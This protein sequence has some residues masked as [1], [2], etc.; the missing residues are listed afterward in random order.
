MMPSSRCCSILPLLVVILVI[1]L[2]GGSCS[3]RKLNSKRHEAPVHGALNHHSNLPFDSNQ[4]PAFYRAYP[5]LAKYRENVSEVYR[6]HR[7]T[8]IWYDTNGVVEFGQTLFGKVGE[9]KDEGISSRFPYTDQINDIFE[10]EKENKLTR[11]ETDIMLTNLY[12]FYTDKV[13]K[14][15]DDTTSTAL[16]WLLPRKELSYPALLDSVIADKQLIDRNDSI[17]YSQYYKLRDVLQ[18]YREIERKGGWKTIEINPKVKSFKPG[19]TAGTIR[20]IRERLFITGDL[21]QD[22]KS[23]RYDE[24]LAAA[25]KK[26]QR[27]NGFN[28]VDRILPEHIRQMNVPIAERIKKIIVNMERCRWIS[29]EFAKSTEYIVVNIPSFRLTF[30]RNGKI[31]LESPVIVGRNVNKTVIFSGMLSYIVFSPYWNVP[32][33]IISKE[34]K[35]GMA[36]DKNYLEKHD[37]EWNNGLV[38]QR[39]GKNNSLGLVKFIFPNSNDIYMHDTPAKSLFARESRAFSHGCIRVGKPRDLAISILKSDSLWTAGKIDAAMNAGKE[40][41][42][43]LKKKIPVYI[44]YLTAWVSAQGEINFYEDIYKRDEPLA[45]LLMAGGTY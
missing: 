17:L 34:I 38:R 2:A 16:G 5:N 3:G 39:P 19:D 28:P 42:Y 13:F 26:Y 11:T 33:S 45:E 25:V 30:V 43:I 4:V 9:L 23:N 22:S 12:L 32:T 29:P 10:N 20:Q 8:C 21:A 24:D 6:K 44:G 15:L 36:K 18:R 37:M 31:E 40:S 35:P 7:F 14:G 27:R 1:S 41:T